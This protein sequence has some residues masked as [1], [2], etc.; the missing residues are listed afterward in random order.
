MED[1]SSKEFQSLS[2]KSD[3]EHGV[4]PRVTVWFNAWSYQNTEQ[5]W[6]GLADSIIQQIAD[7]LKEPE[8]SIMFLLRLH[9]KRYGAD[10]IIQKINEL[11]RTKW[12]TKIHSTIKKYILPIGISASVASLGW[13]DKNHILPVAGLSGL[14]V[15]A[16]IAGLQ[17]FQERSKAELDVK[18]EPTKDSLGQYADLPDYRKKSVFMM[19]V[20]WDM[21]MVLASIPKEYRPM[22]V[23]IDD[24]DRCSE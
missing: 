19:D 17:V 8:E 18:N 11:V 2:I 12:T 22:V 16:M 6:S 24:L 23:F 21:Q 20:V 7:C 13:I 3:E 10:K 1:I 4:K 15:S 5:I 14:G 9:L